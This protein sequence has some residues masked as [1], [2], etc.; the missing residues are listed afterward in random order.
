MHAAARCVQISGVGVRVA[1]RAMAC[2]K[3]PAALY[4]GSLPYVLRYSRVYADESPQK[5]SLRAVRSGAHCATVTTASASG[6]TA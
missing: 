6:P 1:V 2:R 3:L 5:A 4:A